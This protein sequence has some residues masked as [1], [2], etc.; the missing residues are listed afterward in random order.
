MK[1]YIIADPHFSQ[2]NLNVAKAFKPIFADVIARLTTK[3]LGDGPQGW[4]GRG[5]GLRWWQRTIVAQNLYIRVVIKARRVLHRSASFR[6][7]G[8]SERCDVPK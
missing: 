1:L 8:Q 6:P 2:N 3:Q 7:N 4:I 5:L